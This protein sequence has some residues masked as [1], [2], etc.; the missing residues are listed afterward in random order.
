M[1]HGCSYGPMSL[2]PCFTFTHHSPWI[3]NC[4][5]F[6]NYKHFLLVLFDAAFSLAIILR[7]M[8][9][10]LIHCFKPV[11]DTGYFV[12]HDLPVAI[13]YVTAA[14]L[15]VVITCFLCFHLYLTCNSMTTIEY[16]E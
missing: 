7:A 1:Q 9:V 14:L 6:R 3:A 16:R 11:F 10:R 12:G 13:A 4:V 5:G 8:G 15:W 2:C